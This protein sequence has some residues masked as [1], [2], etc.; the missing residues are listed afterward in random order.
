[1]RGRWTIAALLW[2]ALLGSTAA[3]AQEPGRI[4]LTT[5]YPASIGLIWQATQ[6][7]AVRPELSFQRLTGDS[8][9]N[10]A[11]GAESSNWTVSVGASALLYLGEWENLRSYFSPRFMYGRSTGDSTA[12]N[13]TIVSSTSSSYAVTGSFG[14]QYLLN[15]QFGVF[16]EA[17]FGYTRQRNES[18]S[19]SG[20]FRSSSTTNSWGTRT[21]VGILFYF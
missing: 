3:Y 7:V 1:M 18:T 4:G 12:V 9:A 21:A 8:T 19:S 6:Q 11:A 13:T 15:H 16:G 17:G 10:G 20:S 5:G 14:A 2:C